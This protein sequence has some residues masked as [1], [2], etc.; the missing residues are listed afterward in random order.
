MESENKRRMQ[1]K[2]ALIL[3]KFLDENK[4]KSF[5][6][7]KDGTIDLMLV[8]NL[9]KLASATELRPATISSIFN[10]DSIPSITTLILI[11]IKLQRTIVEF[12]NSYDLIEDN[13]INL[14]ELELAK[15]K[16]QERD[17]KFS[18]K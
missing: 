18:R 10:A 7:L 15:K 13:E 5:Q 2:C 16:T 1:L 3:K 12:G 6:N 11:L 9:S 4:S 8:D 14:F 17:R